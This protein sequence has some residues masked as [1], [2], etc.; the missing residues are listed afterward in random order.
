MFFMANYT[1]LDSNW[2]EA[3]FKMMRIHDCQNLI[4]FYKRDLTG[5]ENNRFNYESWF[6]EVKNLFGEGNSKYTQK[7]FE[8]VQR[9]ES[10]IVK[11]LKDF[12]GHKVI[13]EGRFSNSNITFLCNKDNYEKIIKLI[14]EYE[15]K[16][17]FYNDKHGL[18]TG[19]K[20]QAGF[21]R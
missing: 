2:N 11:R 3:M 5:R 16:V 20:D 8:E 6:I 1:G 12:P 17:K 4:N 10:L 18:S 7:E 21:F 13:K 14:E 9:I 15:Y 19:N